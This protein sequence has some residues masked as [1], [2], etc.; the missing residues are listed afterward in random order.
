MKS[1]VIEKIVQWRMG[2]A[3]DAPL[4]DWRDL[5]LNFAS[6]DVLEIDCA[7]AVKIDGTGA[8]VCTPP[9]RRGYNP[10][11][12]ARLVET[13]EDLSRAWKGQDKPLH[14]FVVMQDARLFAS[15]NY[16]GPP[17]GARCTQLSFSR[18]VQTFW[19]SEAEVILW[20]LAAF[21]RRWR[22][23][24]QTPAPWENRSAELFWRGQPS[25]MSYILDE[26]AR[27]VLTGLR[28]YRRWLSY[29]LL[30]EAAE[31]ADAFEL[32]APSYQRLQAVSLC[33]NIPGTDVRFVPMYDQDRKPMEIAAR[34]LG[35]GIVS[36]RLDRAAYWKAQQRCKYVLT[37]PGNDIPSSLRNDLLSG[38]T[39]LMPRPFWE[40]EWFYGLEPGVHYIP[41]RADLADLEA[42]LEWCR[43]NDAQCREIAKAAQA[44]ARTQFEPALEFEVQSRIV[45]R[46]AAQTAPL[47]DS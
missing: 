46:M 39:V 2:A 8:F 25:G 38:C 10:L 30:A 42:R 36:D 33:R 11:K 45:A 22:L 41:L 32:W 35:A 43:E 37:L 40:N 31:D 18:T 19:R 4:F 44:F 3:Y 17:S 23:P 1:S 9:G 5:R 47:G 24:D 21:T 27:P 7:G 20:P 26:D 6:P 28:M 15:V 29:F 14:A 12:L 13:A 34:Y 16:I